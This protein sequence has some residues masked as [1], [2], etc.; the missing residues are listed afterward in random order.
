M[1]GLKLNHF[2]KRGPDAW[3]SV[4]T[5][6]NVYIIQNSSDNLSQSIGV[7]RLPIA[8]TDIFNIFTQTSQELS[9]LGRLFCRGATKSA[10][11]K[12]SKLNTHSVLI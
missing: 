2:T 5:Q 9:D 6:N 8:L 7:P 3:A 1:L 12:T 4:Y 11:I 10:V